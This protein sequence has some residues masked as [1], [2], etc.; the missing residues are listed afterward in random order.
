MTPRNLSVLRQMST[1][2]ETWLD[3]PV[4]ADAKQLRAVLSDLGQ[5]PTELCDL[6]VSYAR[7]QHIYFTA[8]SHKHLY[9]HRWDLHADHCS[10]RLFVLAPS[11]TTVQV[12]LSPGGGPDGVNRAMIY[13]ISSVSVARFDPTELF[14]QQEAKTTSPPSN[15]SATETQSKQQQ[16]TW[17]CHV[18]L[19]RCPD[20]PFN[21]SFM[22]CIMP[23]VH[24]PFKADTVFAWLDGQAY[25]LP[26]TAAFDREVKNAAA[27]VSAVPVLPFIGHCNPGLLRLVLCGCTASSCSI[28]L[29]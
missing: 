28:A 19:E 26:L 17:V 15:T 21:H 25:A 2:P 13:L 20:L 23:A 10:E 6:I 29:I 7:P 16:L 8:H 4:S 3:G 5:W 1:R 9:L 22:T 18:R 14:W 24:S 12:L 11:D 27:S